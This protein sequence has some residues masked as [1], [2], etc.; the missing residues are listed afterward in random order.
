MI[1]KHI[2]Y[3]SFKKISEHVDENMYADEFIS[4]TKDLIFETI[5]LDENYYNVALYSIKRDLNEEVENVIKELANNKQIRY[6]EIETITQIPTTSYNFL[7]LNNV[8]IQG[9]FDLLFLHILLYSNEVNVYNKLK[10]TTIIDKK[11]MNSHF[12]NLIQLRDN[13]YIMEYEEKTIRNDHSI[14]LSSDIIM[15]DLVFDKKISFAKSFMNAI[16]TYINKRLVYMDIENKDKVNILVMCASNRSIKLKKYKEI[17]KDVL[18]DDT[19]FE[20]CDT[21]FIGLDISVEED[22]YVR[23]GL[24]QNIV[25]QDKF[26]IIVSEHC[27]YSIFFPNLN[28]IKSLL[29]NDGIIIS[30]DHEK[31]GYDLGMEKIVGTRY[32]AFF[33]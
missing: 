25:T 5:V 7:I 23:R 16:N 21:Y 24:L 8:E 32:A 6:Y 9:K 17:I 12:K 3:P 11:S 10:T 28:F 4:A 22:P 30:F 1:Y 13:L 29:K 2:K 20:N 33:N 19:S 31:Q 18:G 26:D 15:S 27:M 14:P